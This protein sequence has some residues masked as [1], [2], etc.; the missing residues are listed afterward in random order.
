MSM[1]THWSSVDKA[2]EAHHAFRRPNIIWGR[3]QQ[4]FHACKLILEHFDNRAMGY[5]LLTF[6]FQALTAMVRELR[7]GNGRSG[8]ILAN[9]GVLTSQHAL[10]L[11]IRPRRDGSAYPDK[12]PLPIR[13]TDTPI[14]KVTVQVE[15]GEAKI[16]VSLSRA[17][18]DNPRIPLKLT[19]QTYTVEFNRNG[20]PSKGFIVGRLMS[21]NHRFVANTG[22]AKTLEQLSSGST[23]PIGRIGWV[24]RG[25]GGR[26]MFIFE[27]SAKL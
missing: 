4:L 19:I 22:D 10:C 2:I 8:L 12:N 1:P 20:S 11:S 6:I 14:P 21:S 25:D 13:I 27:Q 7:R 23:E 16:E 26:N 3:R 18:T 17:L 5:S 9:G 15:E 24:K